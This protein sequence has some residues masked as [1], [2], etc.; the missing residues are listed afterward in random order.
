M[1]EMLSSGEWNFACDDNGGKAQVAAMQ[2]A[3]WQTGLGFSPIVTLTCR[4]ARGTYPAE[5]SR[6]LA[7]ES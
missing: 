3:H 4:T 6:R 1:A 5:L 7:T 2:R